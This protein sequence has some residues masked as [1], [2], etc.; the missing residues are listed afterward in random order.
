[1]RTRIQLKK[2]KFQGIQKVAPTKVPSKFCGENELNKVWDA[3]P[4][5]VGFGV[6][7]AQKLVG[8]TSYL[9]GNSQSN[10]LSL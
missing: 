5:M 6:N 2:R 10:W 1:M 9:A 4:P 3:P 7:D 8:T